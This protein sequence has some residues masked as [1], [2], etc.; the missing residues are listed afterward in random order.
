MKRVAHL[1]P[2]DSNQNY[3]FS[4]YA[5]G[6]GRILPWILPSKSLVCKICK[7]FLPLTR[8]SGVRNFSFSDNF[9]YVLDEWSHGRLGIQ[10]RHGYCILISIYL[11]KKQSRG[12]L[13]NCCSEN[14][15]KIAWRTSCNFKFFCRGCVFGNLEKV[16]RTAFLWSRHFRGFFHG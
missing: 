6:F 15:R 4:T 3:S 16:F 2:N 11:Q 5:Q 13:R 12:V 1:I 8:V 9:A 7:H 14:F 10:S